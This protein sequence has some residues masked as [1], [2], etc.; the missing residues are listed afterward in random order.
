MTSCMRRTCVRDAD[1]M[2]GACVRDADVMHGAWVRDADVMHV[3]CVCDADVM[4][5]AC[6]RDADI[7]L[8]ACVRDADVMH[9]ACSRASWSET[10]TRLDIHRCKTDIENNLWTTNKAPDPIYDTWRLF[11]H[12]RLTNDKPC[13]N[14]RGREGGGAGISPHYISSSLAL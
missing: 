4:H 7:M 14:Y 3:V 6:V 9:G 12:V 1:V 8:R 13:S 10:C 2:H 5:D 11:A